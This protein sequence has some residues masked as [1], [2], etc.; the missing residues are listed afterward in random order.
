MTH[1][2]HIEQLI[3]NLCPNG[4]KYIPLGEVTYWDKKFN[5][6]DKSLQP[7]T[8]KYHYYLANELE[9]LESENG[10]IRILYTNNRIAYAE[11]SKLGSTIADAEIVCIPWG[12]NANIKY[13]KGKFVTADNRIA[14]ARDPKVLNTKFLYY[15]LL[16]RQKE[17]DLLYRG[18]GIKHPNMLQV[19]TIPLPLPPLP[20]QEE[21]VR[22]LDAFANL[23]ENIDT[24]IKERERQL[25]LYLVAIL[26][27]IKEDGKNWYKLGDICYQPKERINVEELSPENYV[28]VENMLQN[29]QGVTSSTCVPSTN[30]IKYISGDILLGN[31]RPNLRKIWMADRIGGTNG[32]VITLRRYD[33]YKEFLLP[34]YLYYILSDESFFTYNIQYSRGAKMPRGN[35][36]KIL[37]Y[38]IPLPPLAEQRAIAEKLDTIEALIANLKT[39]HDLRQQQ[40]EYYREH[41][42]NLLK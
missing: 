1:N 12:G 29:R 25:E 10:N 18:A 7:Q 32:D 11:E 37:A 8:R 31:I 21:I 33:K 5:G 38:P 16:T 26:E 9:K 35:K 28:G 17:I 6:V 40:Y 36:E 42:I 23:I 13:Y 14:I 24:E 41:L 20:I 39:E 30:A 3:Q 4:V 15:Y 27:R 19:L 2:S 22:T 34:R